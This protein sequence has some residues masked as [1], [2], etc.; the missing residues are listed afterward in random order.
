LET[1]ARLFREHPDTGLLYGDAHYIDENGNIVGR[2]RTEAFD[3]AK[4][5]WFNFIC[6]PS[7]FF[8]RDVFE[9]VGGVDETL[10]F[11]MDY[12]LW[13][14]IGRE[15]PCRYLPGFLAQYRLHEASKTVSDK[16]LQANCEEGLRLALKYFGWAPLTRV[17]NAC[18]FS[19]RARLPRL[20]SGNRAAV[21]AA[22]LFCTLFRS[23]RL[24]RGIRSEDLKL[25]KRENFRKLFKSR[26]EIMTGRGAGTPGR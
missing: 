18:N 4:L 14:R 25:L 3:L 5:A 20:L 15:F 9:A 7:A 1:V 21:I 16:T 19:S 26:I 24:N 6:Q 2:Y 10:Q 13:I 23:L 8:R 11:A 22:S 17:Y 12:D